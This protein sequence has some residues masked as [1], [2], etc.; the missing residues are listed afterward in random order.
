LALVFAAT[1][2]VTVNIRRVPVLNA[3]PDGKATISPNR[4]APT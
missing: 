4:P 1:V 3:W 2:K